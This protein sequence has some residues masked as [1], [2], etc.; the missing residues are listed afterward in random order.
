MSLPEQLAQP[1]LDEGAAVQPRADEE[2]TV[3]FVGAA[4]EEPGVLRLTNGSGSIAS[5]PRW[6]PDGRRIAFLMSDRCC[7]DET[8]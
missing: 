6:S 4:V 2:R 5:Y 1:L 7:N 8:M 3:D